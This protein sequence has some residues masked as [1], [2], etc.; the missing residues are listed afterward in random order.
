MRPGMATLRY[1]DCAAH[2]LTDAWVFFCTETVGV[3]LMRLLLLLLFFILLTAETLGL[4]LS[5]APGLSVKN[6]MLYLILLGIMIDT[7]LHRNR[8][9]EALSVVV[10]YAL[11]IAYAL[12]TWLV[13]LLVIDYPG[14]SPLRSLI[15][16]KGGL[17][18]HL[19]VFLVFF[20]GVLNAKDALWL[21]K[22]LIWTVMIVN[23]VS[24]MDTLNLPDLRLMDEDKNGRMMGPLGEP[25]QF[26]LFI[27]LFLPGAIALAVVERGWVRIIATFGA[28][29][30]I[31]AFVLTVSRGGTV[32]LVGGSLLAAVFLRRFLR[33]RVVSI[34]LLGILL[35]SIAAAALAYVYGFGE[36][37]YDRYVGQS[38]G[39]G[40]E[41]SSGRTVI[42]AKALAKMTEQPVTFVIGYGWNSY[43]TFRDFGFAPHNTYLGVF[44]ELGAIGLTL[45]LIAYGSVLRIARM[46]LTG[47]QPEVF[48]F[49]IAFSF[50]FLTVLVG[51]FFVE[52]SLPWI[53]AWAYAGASLRLA[54]TKQDL[55]AASASREAADAPL[56]RK[57]LGRFD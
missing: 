48:G 36:L 21:L 41:V 16:W 49:L 9:P 31:L 1:G 24:V 13:I 17:V 33:L 19:I 35:M 37:L 25:N 44:F 47:A 2:D 7:A 55:E 15:A 38:L 18:D 28:S 42:W 50:G 5:L 26:A 12:F 51:V 53:F 3:L 23:I 54:L 52:L 46:S 56:P 32:G 30:S 14:Y 39:G 45:I 27:S 8:V 29:V 11:C 40:Y 20:Y 34:G 4:D 10:P 43:D 6:A 57:H 22:A